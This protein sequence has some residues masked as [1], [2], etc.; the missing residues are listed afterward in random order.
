MRAQQAASPIAISALTDNLPPANWKRRP[1][2][3]EWSL[4]E[5]ACH[6]RDVEIEVNLPRLKKIR[7][8]PTPFISAVESDSWAIERD[9]QSQAGLAA[10]AAFADARGETLNLLDRLS[11]AEWQRLARHAIFGPTTL[12]ELATVTVEHDRVHLRQVQE[13]LL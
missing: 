11:P 5:I 7:D 9:Y 10:L 4:T 8:E 3:T 13:N 12:Q 1:R 2:E 6:L